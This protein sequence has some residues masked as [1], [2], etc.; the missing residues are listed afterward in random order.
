MTSRELAL[1]QP[2]REH[3]GVVAAAVVVHVDQPV[4]PGLQVGVGVRVGGQGP[5]PLGALVQRTTVL[6][7]LTTITASIKG[8]SASSATLTPTIGTNHITLTVPNTKPTPKTIA[9]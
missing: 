2:Q 1:G 9:K 6:R 5:Q 8:S 4:D 3:G 7:R